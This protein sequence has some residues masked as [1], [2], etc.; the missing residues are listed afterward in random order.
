M[1]LLDIATSIGN[2]SS[3]KDSQFGCEE[4]QRVTKLFAKLEGKYDLSHAK[5][6]L[7]L[8]VTKLVSDDEKFKQALDLGVNMFYRI[9][10]GEV[11]SIK[12]KHI[13]QEEISDN[14]PDDEVVETVCQSHKNHVEVTVG[15]LHECLTIQ[16]EEYGAELSVI[17]DWVSDEDHVTVD[18]PIIELGTDS[19][20]DSICGVE[21]ANTIRPYK[22]WSS[23]KYSDTGAIFYEVRLPE[24]KVTEIVGFKLVGS[25]F[26]RYTI[27][28]VQGKIYKRFNEGTTVEQ[29]IRII[30]LFALS[31]LPKLVYTWEQQI[32][33]LP[34]ADNSNLWIKCVT[35][36]GECRDVIPIKTPLE[37]LVN[38]KDFLEIY[39]SWWNNTLCYLTKGVDTVSFVL[40]GRDN[41]SDIILMKSTKST[42][43]RA[44]RFEDND[45]YCYLCG[46]ANRYS[47][48]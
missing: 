6:T 1:G 12:A 25:L 24:S 10:L 42:D 26:V 15:F 39:S 20:E 48:L 8:L 3:D 16:T 29:A 27:L 28:G 36:K 31:G 44:L 33:M 40:S 21:I 19:K 5:K 34:E 38:S 22:Y 37:S 23:T 41:T 17:L 35:S 4:L 18:W 43:F 13:L 46:Y 7:K 14:F 45:F 30:R 47:Y 32:V 2:Q 9:L 11:N